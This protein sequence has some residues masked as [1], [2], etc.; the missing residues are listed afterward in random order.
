MKT[1]IYS[2]YDA[3]PEVFHRPFVEINNKSAQ[4]AFISSLEDN[5]NKKDYTLYRIGVFDD[6]TGIIE[7]TKVPIQIMT[8]FEIKT[9]EQEAFLSSSTPEEQLADLVLMQK[10]SG[11][12]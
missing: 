8:G 9:P 7:P 1:N 6:E 2:V 10:Q 12:K 4:R 5:K 11:D 3:I